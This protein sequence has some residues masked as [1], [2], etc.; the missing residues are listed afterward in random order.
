MEDRKGEM[1]KVIIVQDFKNLFNYLPIEEKI[2]LILSKNKE[3]LSVNEICEKIKI[4]KRTARKCLSKLENKKLVKRKVGIKINNN[5]RFGDKWY[6]IKNFHIKLED[7]VYIQYESTHKNNKKIHYLLL[8]KFIKIDKNFVR[9]IGLLDAEKTKFRVKKTTLEFVN[10]EPLI[11][12]NI[13]LFFE[14]FYI[15]KEYWRWRLIFNGNI[16]HIVKDKLE[17][18]IKF[19]IEN[20]GL[21][22]TNQL[23]SS[24]YFTE[25]KGKYKIKTEL[26]SLNLNYNN[27][28]FHNFVENLLNKIK[29]IIEK[30]ENFILTY[31]SGFLCGE[32]YVGDRKCREIQVGSKDEKQLDFVKKL[33]NKVGIGTSY[34]KASSTSPPRILICGKNNFLKIYKMGVFDINL[35]KKASLVRR[36]LGYKKMDSMMKHILKKDLEKLDAMLKGRELV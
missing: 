25:A 19:W 21:S 10:S 17:N 7:K 13:I 15:P 18:I 9:C 32:A 30:N 8:P 27:L 11:I 20:T 23:L 12:N 14:I 22:A 26:G 34:A 5:F 33:L 28:F 31:L 29:L 35:K 6:A 4:K 36:L 24:P 1:Q 3:I 16:K 2:H